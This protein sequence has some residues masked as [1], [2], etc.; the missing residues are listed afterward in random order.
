[1]NTGSVVAGVDLGDPKLAE[2]VRHGL[3]QVEELL[4][5]ELSHG[6]DFLTEAVLHLAKAGGKRFRPLFTILTAQLGPKPYDPAIVTAA[7]VVELVHLATLYHDDVMD[8]A[9]MRR[10]AP[11]ANSR[12]GNS[13]AIL[14][15]D[16]LF[17]HASRLVSTLGPEAVRII[18]ETFAELVTGQMRETIGVREMQDPVEH[19]LRVVWEKTGSLIAASGRFGGVF[20]AAPGSHVARME[21]LGD[22]VGTAFQ[23]SD[24][25]IDI[26]SASAQS[27]KTPGTDLREGVRTLP[28][29][30]A[31]RE[32][33][34]VGDR[35]RQLLSRPIETDEEVTEALQLLEKSQGIQ[36]A[37]VK[38][39]G[40]ADMARAE[41]AQL[42]QGPANE[43][44]KRLVDYTIERVG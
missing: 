4:V 17:A 27:G 15:G 40:Y 38:L 32:E 3:E 2:T 10:G 13:V 5:D 28:V 34:P 43:A 22:A 20:S 6:E 19:Y 1:M 12:W 30:Y 23:I 8:E 18:A 42:P 26:S 29:L 37:K 41:L 21:R 31:L 7:T 9:S 25:I 36:L 33:G 14:A 39:S 16:Y 44:L 11:S 24:D 35:L